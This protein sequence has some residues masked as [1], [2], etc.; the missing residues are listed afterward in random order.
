MSFVV[1]FYYLLVSM[2]PSKKISK[3]LYDFNE[4]VRVVV[5][6]VLAVVLFGPAINHLFT[7]NYKL[8]TSAHT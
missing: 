6:V 3:N 1:N 4:V 8:I 7:D 5:V 2:V